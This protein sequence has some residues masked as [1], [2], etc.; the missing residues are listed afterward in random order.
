MKALELPRLF[1]VSSPSLNPDGSTVVFS[2]THPDLGADATVGQLW[3]AATDGSTPPRRFTRGFR[4]TAPA[5]SPD[6]SLIAFLRAAPGSAAQLHVVAADGGEPV[7][8]TDR[9]L[10]VA[11]F[12][13]APDGSA[14]AFTSRDPQHGRYGTV[15]GLDAAAEAPR[16]ITTLR[17]K[18]NG[19]G[20]T[21]DRR[22]QLFVVDVPPIDAEPEYPAAASVLG[23]ADAPPASVGQLT[24]ADADVGAFDWRGNSLVFVS[25][26][27]PE[28]DI[29]LRSH[30]YEVPRSGGAPQQLTRDDHTLTLG[31]VAVTTDG[32]VFFTAQDVGPT[33][34]DFIG[35]SAGV[36]VFDGDT[37]TRLTEPDL[38]FG[39]PGAALTAHGESSVLGTSRDRGAVQLFRVSRNE[40]VPLTS[41]RDV[42]E[43]QSALGDTIAVSFSSRRSHGEIGVL[44]SGAIRQLTDFHT[45]EPSA[46]VEHT[47]TARDGYEVHG[48]VT[49]PEGEGPHPVLLMI[50]GGPFSSYDSHFFD[51]AE[52]LAGA[53]YAV[54]YCN[55]R[56]S[57]GYGEEHGRAIR[58]RMGTLDHTDVLDFL[59]GVI[60]AEPSLNGDRLGILGGSYGGYLTAWTIAHDSRF[61]AAIVERGFLDPEVFPGTSDIGD[62]FGQEYMGTDLEAI[63][64]QSPQAV[65]HL[66]TTPTLVIHSAD[67]LRCPLGQAERYYA[68]LKARGVESE[69][70]IFPGE[71][72]ELTRSGRPRHRVERFDAILEWWSRYLPIERR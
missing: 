45:I 67:D 21:R 28:R 36:F 64:A 5:F 35:R 9:L 56:G 30:L 11:S 49:L 1:S 19:T 69:L 63:R 55:P 16:R 51:E 10:G 24:S 61:A 42:I 48:W 37:A 18:S 29:D 2:A 47:I 58:Q 53:G 31:T 44:E 32:S 38:D 15:E 60:A 13:W 6:G 46:T 72:H 65:A 20:Y 66:V 27:H 33:G 43:G 4:D 8:L 41:G 71:N 26:L 14:L 40:Q 23:A 7:R 59:E 12:R 34:R 50:H 57:A 3:V 62:F 17:Y 70:L 25:A 68:T 54:V 39:E 52:V 22:T